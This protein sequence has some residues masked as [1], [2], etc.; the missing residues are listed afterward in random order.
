MKVL[1]VVL[2]IGLAG[3][4][5]AHDLW[6]EREGGSIA[7]YYGHKHSRHKGAISL[8]YPPDWVRGAL[9]FDLAGARAP[10]Q[11]ED[12]YPYRIRG[13]CAA[14]HV[15]ISSGHWTKTPYGTEN[16]AKDQVR[17]PLK[18]WISHESV[19]RIDHWAEPLA[20]PL[21]GGLELTPLE[22][23]GDGEIAS[24]ARDADKRRRAASTALFIVASTAALLSASMAVRFASAPNAPDASAWRGAS[25]GFGV[26]GGLT[27]IIGLTLALE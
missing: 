3:Q 15:A 13:E 24:E 23:L 12:T 27:A 1:L 4:A 26:L 9:C 21:A 25:I 14:A 8:E 7:L 17:M 20:R 5:L 19:K 16:L 10:F 11:S 18:S 2:A 22:R 6:L